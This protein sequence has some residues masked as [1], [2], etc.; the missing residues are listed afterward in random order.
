V[1]H[2]AFS[3]DEV[4]ASANLV[5]SSENQQRCFEI[6]NLK[7][8]LAWRFHGQPQTSNLGGPLAVCRSGKKRVLHK[9]AFCGKK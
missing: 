9:V 2:F 7:G 3:E 8:H 5:S 1:L 6:R 4:V